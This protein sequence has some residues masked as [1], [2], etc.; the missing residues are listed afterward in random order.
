MYSK[1]FHE[2]MKT[3]QSCDLRST[4]TFEIVIFAKVPKYL[5]LGGAQ[6]RL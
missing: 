6:L 4:N 5:F 1:Y 2:E 3:T